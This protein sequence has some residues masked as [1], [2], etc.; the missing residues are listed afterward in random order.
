MTKETPKQLSI[1]TFNWHEP[2]ISLLAK[3]GH[4]FDIAEPKTG[5]GGV[6]RWS[7]SSRPVP[8][9]GKIISFDEGIRN[10]KSGQ[11]DIAICHNVADLK[12]VAQ[13]DTPSILTFH[14]KLSTELALGGDTVKR[15]DYIASVGQLIKK[16]NKL[17][18]VSE[19]KRRDWDLPE[20]EIITPGV[21]IK[22][23]KNYRGNVKAV[24]RVANRIRERDIM[25]G[26]SIG[27]KITEG[28][29]HRLVGDNP[30][31]PGSNPANSHEELL[32][33]FASHRLYLSTTLAPYEDGYN[34]AMLEAMATGA[35]VVSYAN[36][37]S[38]ITDG[39]DGFLSDDIDYL[40]DAIMRLFTDVELAT[41]IGA[42]GQ[43]RVVELF[44]VKTFTERWNMVFY[45]AT[46]SGT[47][48]GPQGE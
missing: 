12:A 6:R 15:S 25:L 13:Y 32:E 39:V 34:L 1:L 17:V 36:P 38:F 3:T 35:P 27:D 46:R 4:F 20:S 44:S 5:R 48:P 23:A 11:Y 43:K 41:T 33:L 7:V 22:G 8:Q 2:Y 24:L 21:D 9:N 29:A 18:F 26:A 28:F 31:Y 16:A 42:A 37:T 47:R 19:S 14:N 30:S 40:R 10:L 45:S